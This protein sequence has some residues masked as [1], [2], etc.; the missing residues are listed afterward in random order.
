M[1]RSILE[2]FKKEKLYAFLLPPVAGL[3]IYSWL[4]SGTKTPDWQNS[5]A[6][7]RFE[8]AEGQ[9]QKKFQEAGSL[10]RFFEGR[11][12]EWR[13]LKFASLAASGALGLGI[14]LDFLLMFNPSFRNRLKLSASFMSFDWK[15][16][17]LFKVILLFIAAGFLSGMILRLVRSF[18]FPNLSMNFYILIH[19]TLIDMTCFILIVL[20]VRQAGGNSGAMGLHIP[21][22]KFFREVMVGLAA[23]TAVLPVFLTTLFLV[24]FMAELLHYR[25]TPH[26]LVHV[27][28]EEQERSPGLIVYSIVL[29]SLIGPIL[30]EIFFRGFCYPVLRNKIGMQWAL[31]ITSALFAL[32]HEN[33]FAFWPIFVLGLALGY[34]YEKRGSLIAPMV[35]HVTHNAVFLAYF[36]WAKRLITGG[37]A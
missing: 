14:L 15:F 31:I 35:L 26:P 11:P 18:L 19:T 23:Y 5:A 2:F 20:I 8:Q 30:E 9:L 27:F 36:F 24:L 25:P 22:G 17:M 10:E 3:I 34:L 7:R 32:I 12:V 13:F 37:A 6:V 33:T 21:D 29:A 1:I 16:S 28:L 4:A